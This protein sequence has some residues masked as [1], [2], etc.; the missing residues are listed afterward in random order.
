[1]RTARLAL[2]PSIALC[3]TVAVAVATP[4]HASVTVDNV[5]MSTNSVTVHGLNVTTLNVSAHFTSD[6]P[7][8]SG[9]DGCF[10]SDDPLVAFYRT[11]G[12]IADRVQS[13]HFALTSGTPLDGTWTAT[14]PVTSG[15]NGD[16]RVAGITVGGVG[17]CSDNAPFDWTPGSA[18]DPAYGLHVN[19]INWPKVSLTFAPSPADWTADTVAVSGRATLDDGTPIANMSVSLGAETPCTDYAY[20]AGEVVTTGSD[21][22]FAATPVNVGQYDDCVSIDQP[23][24]RGQDD[25]NYLARTFAPARRVHLTQ[26]LAPTRVRLGRSIDVSGVIGQAYLPYCV[27]HLQRYAAGRWHN[28]PATLRVAAPTTETINGK[29]VQIQSYRFHTVPPVAGNV[30]YRLYFPTQHCVGAYA[31]TITATMLVGVI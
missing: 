4:A 27:L 1:M 23:R 14:A 16:W 25:V 26:S 19:G 10:W 9:Q 2:I 29:Q 24:T 18:T 30:R 15:W 13:A 22:R 20:F 12:G 8:T 28:V 21:G 17:S 31:G 5:T 3:L 6:Q 11:G 7:I